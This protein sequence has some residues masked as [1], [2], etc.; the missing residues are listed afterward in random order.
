MKITGAFIIG[1]VFDSI[2]LVWAA[3][4]DICRCM[5]DYFASFFS[6]LSFSVRKIRCKKIREK[7]LL[8]CVEK[9][10]ARFLLYYRFLF[11]F[12][13]FFWKIDF[14]LHI[15]H[16]TAVSLWAVPH[17]HIPDGA[18]SRTY[19]FKRKSRT[20]DEPHSQTATEFEK[21]GNNKKNETIFLHSLN[22]TVASASARARSYSII[23]SGASAH[24][25]S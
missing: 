16:I 1:V 3:I 7:L 5:I 2:C 9:T 20:A 10:N 17:I 11:V 24:S 21:Y 15:L 13:F 22:T 25:G 18:F 14:I 19:A 6:F 12:F 23:F 4:P 8:F